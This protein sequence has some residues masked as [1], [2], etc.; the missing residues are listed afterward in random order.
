M[1]PLRRKAFNSTF[2]PDKYKEYLA[3]LDKLVGMHIDFRI[4]ETPVF[5]PKELEKML[6]T[7]AGEI[8]EQVMSPD[9]LKQ[10]TTG[11]SQV[12]PHQAEAPNESDHPEFVQ[13]D[14]AVIQ[15]EDGSLGIR[16][17]ELQGFPSIYALQ[18]LMGKTA[19]EFYELEGVHHLLNGLSSEEYY[20]LLR[21]VILRDSHAQN[22]ILLEVD[23]HHQKTKP[24][25]IWTEK[26]LGI[27][28]VDISTIE[29]DGKDLF[30][31][32][33]E[34]R[35][36]HIDRI[37]NRAIIDELEQRKTKFAFS[38]TDELNLTWVCHPNWYFRISKYALPF[39]KH[40]TVPHTTFLDE[41]NSLPDNLDLYV[42]KPLFSFAGTG[43]IVSPTHKHIEQIPDEHRHHYILQQKVEYAPVLETPSGGT[44]V[45]LRVMFIWDKEPMAVNLVVRTGRGKMMGVAFN[46]DMDWVGA[47]CGLLE[48]YG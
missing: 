15:N 9:Y 2:T 36:V 27:R 6:I 22:V 13:I 3:A 26:V 8:L 5:I 20:E 19:I 28:T 41:I 40:P 1:I 47:T 11:E 12:F 38:F 46:K 24:D 25:F 4:N 21:K 31:R 32:N 33:Q 34:G 42:L 35:R 29:K 45:E 7:S 14:F 30:Y 39:I 18:E 10:F 16:L 48:S 43:V 37:Y 23:P 44:K 17:I